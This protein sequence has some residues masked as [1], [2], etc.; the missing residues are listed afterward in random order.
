MDVNA[1]LRS[2]GSC[3]LDMLRQDLSQAAAEAAMVQTYRD[4]PRALQRHLPI[5]FARLANGD[6]APLI[7]HCSAGKDRTGVLAAVIQLALGVSREHVFADYLLTERFRDASALEA[8]I[9]ELLRALLGKEPSR[10]VVLALAAVRKSYLEAAFEVI[11]GEHGSL[12]R[13]LS[14]SGV[15]STTLGKARERL[16]EV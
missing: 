3:I 2:G 11:E 5:L 9:V 10:G 8:T 13:Y 1:D 16:L 14:A 15:D 4:I 7:I 12:G 6:G